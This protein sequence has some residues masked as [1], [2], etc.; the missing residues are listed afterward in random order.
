MKLSFVTPRF[1]KDIVGGAEYAIGQL[2]KN[3]VE[4]GDVQAEILTTTAGDERT[5]SQKY[6]VG[7]ETIDGV[8]VKRFANKAIVRS[9]FDLWSQKHLTNPEKM[10]VD[11][12]EEWLVRQ[13]PYSPDLLNA[14][15]N[16]ESQAVVF[17]PMLSSPTSHGIFR[18]KVPSVLHP[19][20]HDEP[21]ARMPG[22]KKVV[23]HAS[24]LSFSTVS[25]QKLS[26]ELYGSQLSKQAVLGFGIDSL[27]TAGKH[28]AE[29]I[30]NRFALETIFYCCR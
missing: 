14:I 25:E 19:A 11:D 18:A 24:F 5:W 22:Y 2:A 27:L 29:S 21:L 13:G 30:L 12:F 8:V 20:L 6:D 1:G 16:C 17:H 9:E 7:S 26:S 10:T 3:C 28:E 4:F 15:E 23:N